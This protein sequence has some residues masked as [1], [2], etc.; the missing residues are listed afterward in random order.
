[1]N[2]E[3]QIL[4][5]KSIMQYCNNNSFGVQLFVTGHIQCTKIEQ[6]IQTTGLPWLSFGGP[7]LNS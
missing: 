4:I 7:W 3:L 2:F 6:V 5:I 1:M